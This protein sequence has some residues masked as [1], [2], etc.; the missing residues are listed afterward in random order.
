MFN[1]IYNLLYNPVNFIIKKL[2]KY[3]TASLLRQHVKPMLK[4]PESKVLPHQ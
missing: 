1:L 2:G 4:Q 3:K